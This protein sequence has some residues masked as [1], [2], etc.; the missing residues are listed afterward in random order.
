MLSDA[1]SKP[2]RSVLWAINWSLLVLGLPLAFFAVSHP[3]NEYMATMGVKALDCQG[4]FETYVFAVPAGLLYGAGLISN[5]IRW[6]RPVN[7]FVSLLCALVC[8]AIAMNVRSAFVEE[9]RTHEDCR[10]WWGETPV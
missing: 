10:H 3:P 4:P 6:R 5:G 7:M 8:V 9:Q 1:P 2:V